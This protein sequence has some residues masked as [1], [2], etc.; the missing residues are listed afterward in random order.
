MVGPTQKALESRLAEGSLQVDESQLHAAEALDRLAADLRSV[1]PALWP[2]SPKSLRGV[3]LFGPVGRG[4][5]MLMDM[6]FAAAPITPK[7][8][9]HFQP[10]MAQVHALIGVWRSGDAAARRTTFG[11]APIFRPWGDDPIA[12]VADRLARQARLLCFDEFE[13]VD[14][15]DAM[16]LGRLFDALFERGVTL[17]ATSNRPPGGLYEDGLNR[18]LFLPFIAMLKARLEIVEVA[19]R[20]DYRIDRLRAAGT[21][22]APLEAAARA[23]FDALW[24][25][26]KAGAT[27]APAKIEVL[28]RLLSFPRSCGGLLRAEFAALCAQPLGSRDYL[29]LTARF[30]TL[31]IESVPR[32]GPERRDEARRLGLLVDALYEAR[33]RLVILAEDEPDRLYPAGER[34]FEFQRAASRL[35]EMRSAIWLDSAR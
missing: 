12:P 29:A 21:W 24:D 19:G 23:R 2:F 10:F 30:H 14:I 11:A 3:Y 32:L 13:V 27:E 7:L 34:S 9:V 18:Q 6:F 25:D 15:A 17:V 5:S 31:F 33:A 28:G 8:R 26:M 22:F 1:S 16:I 20:R 4:K 35:E